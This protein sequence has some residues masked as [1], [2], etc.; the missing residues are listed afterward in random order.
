MKRD[1]L[2][3]LLFFSPF[4][5]ISQNDTI[6]EFKNFILLKGDTLNQFNECNHKQGKWI[7]FRPKNTYKMHSVHSGE[8]TNPYIK[9]FSVN[10]VKCTVYESDYLI[11]AIGYYCCGEKDSIWRFY[12]ENSTLKKEIIFNNGIVENDFNI[13]DEKGKILMEI[14]K[15]NT[16]TF[17]VKKFSKENILIDEKILLRKDIEQLFLSEP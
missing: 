15:V 3:I 2:I 12:H 10:G 9:H 8:V 7:Y 11:E 6:W 5:S 4:I 17:L 13:Y 14:Q 16:E 1:L